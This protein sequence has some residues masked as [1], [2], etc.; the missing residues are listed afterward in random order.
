MMSRSSFPVIKVLSSPL[1][2]DSLIR[3]YVGVDLSEFILLEFINLRSLE[4]LAIIIQIFSAP[5]PPLTTTSPHPPL[6]SPSSV[7]SIM[8]MS[9]TR[10]LDGTPQASE[11]LFIFLHSLFFMFLKPDNLNECVRCFFGLLVYSYC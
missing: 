8:C 6:L 1:A 9:I 5:P 3:M 10:S 11:A 2:V 4:V 7:I